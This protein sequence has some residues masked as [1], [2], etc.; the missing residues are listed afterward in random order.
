MNTQDL[1]QCRKE[2]RAAFQTHGVTGSNRHN[3]PAHSMQR[4]S[5]IDGHDQARMGAAER[6]QRDAAAYHAL[7]VRDNAKDRAWSGKLLQA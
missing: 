5:F 1:H 6:S 3:Y 4:Q 7:S 2:G